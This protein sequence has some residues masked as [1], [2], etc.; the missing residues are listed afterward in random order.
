VEVYNPSA[1]IKINKGRD[2]K[3]MDNTQPKPEETIATNHNNRNSHKGLYLSTGVI[4]GLVLSMCICFGLCGIIFASSF[5]SKDQKPDVE[6]VLDEFM[7]AMV[8][9][10]VAKAYALFSVRAKQNV[11]ITNLEE[12]IKGKNY[13]LFEGYYE[14]KIPDLAL[15]SPIFTFGSSFPKGTVATAK[16]FVSYKGGITGKIDATLEE[17]DG[18]WKLIYINVTVPPEKLNSAP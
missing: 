8:D 4:L 10:S 15:R 3:E 6:K 5:Q 16:G 7:R 1:L 14:T 13:V 2:I 9:K 17:E 12:M 11:S 18:K